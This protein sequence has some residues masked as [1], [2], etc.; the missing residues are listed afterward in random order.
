VVRDVARVVW[1]V[2][3][4]SLGS[5]PRI[6]ASDR[7]GD[8]TD[9][10][11]YVQTLAVC[12]PDGTRADSNISR[13]RPGRQGLDLV[14]LRVDAEERAGVGVDD[15]DSAFTCRDGTGVRPADAT[16]DRAGPA[17][18]ATTWRRSKVG[19]GGV[20]ESSATSRSTWLRRPRVRR[21]KR[22]E[23]CVAVRRLGDW[24]LE[25][26][27][28]ARSAA[29]SSWKRRLVG[30]DLE[31]EGP[32]LADLRIRRKLVFDE[33]TRRI[34]KKDLPTVTDS[35]DACRTMHPEAHVLLAR[36]PWLAGVQ[37][38]PHMNLDAFGPRMCCE[39]ALSLD[40]TRDRISGPP[41]SGEE[42]VTLRVDFPSATRLEA[43]AQDALMLREDRVVARA[44]L[45]R[46]RVEPSIS[47]KRKVMVPV[48]SSAI[49]H[50]FRSCADPTLAQVEIHG[51]RA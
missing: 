21:T 9:E 36:G 48:G 19:G 31:L 30:Q 39:R 44:E 7:R 50:P 22:A 6:D 35:T 15:P 23:A 16:V 34:G 3:A 26:R 1:Q 32:E 4:R 47:V 8:R 40:R 13:C 5:R 45:A 10:L 33:L 37:A 14:G 46:S 28:L 11:R 17:S 38:H 51:P 18:T 43:L 12:H 24:R 27:E 49:L 2:T 20:P 29:A 25:R 42:R 41:E